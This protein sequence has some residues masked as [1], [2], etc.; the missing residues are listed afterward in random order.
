MSWLIGHTGYSFFD[1]WTLAH[2]SFWF[3]TGSTL[4]A[5]KL[6]RVISF[7]SCLGVAV[8]WEVFE[9]FAEKKWPDIWLSPESWWNSWCCDLLT[10]LMVL[11]AFYGFDRWRPK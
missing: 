10:T 4:A 5:L 3:V 7:F 9:H 6:N 1:Y 8:G 11:V 2:A